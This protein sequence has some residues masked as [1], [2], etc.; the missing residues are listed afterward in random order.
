[1]IRWHRKRKIF[2]YEDFNVLSCYSRSPTQNINDDIEQVK[3]ISNLKCKKLTDEDDVQVGLE[4]LHVFIADLLGRN[5]IPANIFQNKL[6]KEYEK[7]FVLTRNLKCI[8]WIV[9]CLVHVGF[10]FVRLTRG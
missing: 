2:K 4:V 6:K 10:H 7:K 5:T 3:A 8:V 9:L 1:M